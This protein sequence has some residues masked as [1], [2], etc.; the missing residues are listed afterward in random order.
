MRVCFISHSAG[1]YGAELALLELLPGLIK[2]GVDCKVLVP[3]KGPLLEALDQL[4]IEWRVIDYPVWMSRPRSL[5]YC[6]ARTLK[7]LVM[8]V[9]IAQVI[10]RWKCDVVYTN[11]VVVGAGAFAAWL[12]RKPHVWHFHES[13]YRNPSQKFDLGER[14]VM[15]LMDYLSVAIIVNSHSVEDDC[16][17][18][19]NSTK[20]RV[21]YQSVTLHEADNP[22]DFIKAN[23]CF[24]CVIIGSLHALKGQDEAINALA[25]VVRR[26]INA[27]L[28]I[29]GDGEK[30]FLATLH[31]QV[32]DL[33]LERRVK[34]HG[35]AVDPM[36]L[37]R[38]ADV[39]LVCSRWEAFWAC[40]G[41]GDA[42]RKAGYRRREGRN[43]RIDSR[44]RNWSAV[45]RW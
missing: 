23:Q 43:S 39:T 4:H 45:R 36:P 34:F 32:R 3:E 40:Y 28:L 12:A 26:G 42:R 7:S 37:I 10:A 27:R 18:C 1:R 14:R 16:T 33:G 21:I 22:D 5:P 13:G 11:T 35:Y 30:R 25:E 31:Q 17:R 44:W 38:A 19:I 15:R 9:R 29:V 2:L 8:A 20:M 24:Q 41:R 6:I